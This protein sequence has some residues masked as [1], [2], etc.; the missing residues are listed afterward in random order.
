MNASSLSFQDIILRLQ[1]YWGEQGCV[2][3]QPYDSEVGAGTFHTA[4]T[5][6][7]LGPAEWRTCYAQPCRRPADG[8]YGE[9]PNRMQHYYQFQVLIKPSPV[10]A[11]ELYLGSLA[12]IGL[13]PNDHDVRFVE[14]DWENPSLGAWGLGWEVWLNGMEV[15]QFTYFQQVGGIEV[16]PVPV[17][18]TYGLERIAMY[19]QGVNSVYD[20]VWSY[21]PDGTTLADYVAA[22]PEALG[23]DCAKFEQFPVLT[24]FID[25]S[26]NLSIQV[27]PSIDYALKIE[28][29]YGKTEMWYVLDCVPGAYLYYGFTHEISK[30]EF[31]ERIKNTTLTEVLNAV[32]VHKGD[33]FFIPAGTLHAI[34]K[35]IAIAEV[36]QN[37]NVTYRGYDYGRVG[38]D[39]KPRALH[40]EKALDVTLRTPPVKHD[41]GGHLARC[42]YFTVDAKNGDFDGV[43]DEKSFVSLL[44]TDGAGELTCGGETVPGKKGYSYFL[45]ANS[46]AYTVKGQC[47][48][49]VTV[50]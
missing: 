48:T 47:Q 29:Q 37:S 36:Q 2:I 44:I 11:Q 38:A 5:L 27:H 46:G 9:N 25:A 43:A 22:H 39:G 24:K 3:M 14:D 20:L 8:R 12:A 13:A 1:Q 4:T 18:I 49:L 23:T 50:V 26:K 33:C 40:V 21:L 17:E 10:N 15:T 30:E 42:E 32:P 7:S 41:F 28:H 19:A 45:P 16:D 35:G 31:A 6:R 34:C